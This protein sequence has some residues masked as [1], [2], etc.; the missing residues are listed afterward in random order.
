MVVA[1]GPSK[2]KGSCGKVTLIDR[3][4]SIVLTPVLVFSMLLSSLGKSLFAPS[5]L[6]YA[7][8]AKVVLSVSLTQYAQRETIKLIVLQTC[9]Q[10]LS[11]S[12]A[13]STPAC[14]KL[15]GM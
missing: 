6:I 9:P 10:L 11:K 2:Y 8:A 13:V 15:I 1:L 7:L 12:L 14:C 3:E 5:A 4:I